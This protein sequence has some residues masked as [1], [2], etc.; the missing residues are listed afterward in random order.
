MPSFTIQTPKGTR[1]IGDGYPAFIVAEMSAN[2]QQ[3]Y[4][5]AAAIIKAAAKAGADAIKLQ[6]YTP[7]SMTI[8]S[9]KE[10]FKVGGGGNPDS[11]SGETLYSIYQKSSTPQEWHEPLQKLAEKLGLVFFS[12]AFDDAAVDFLETLKVPM[13]KIA[14]YEVTHIPLLKKIARTGKPVIIS[15][16]FASREEVELA[17]KTLRENGARDICVLHC[18]TAYSSNPN[19]EEINLKT[20]LDIR[21]KYNV[22]CGF[23]DNNAGIEIPLQAVNMGA[24]VIEKHVIASSKDKSFDANFSLDS[25]MLKKFVQ[26]VRRA[27]KIAGKVNYGIQGKAEEH[28]LRYRRS[29]FVVEDIKAGEIFTTENIKVIRPGVGLPPKHYEEILGKKAKEDLER[30]TPLEWNLLYRD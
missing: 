30:G 16:G 7:D 12:S 1:T 10:W 11:W 21:D 15:T 4:E 19:T 24:S 25:Q 18:V 23:S 2:H 14:S 13:Y 29:I 26:A 5:K 17:I 3:N 6:T 20:M 22:I 8:D 9:D 28:N 27:E